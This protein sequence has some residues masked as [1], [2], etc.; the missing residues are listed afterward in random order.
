MVGFTN[1]SPLAKVCLHIHMSSH[2]QK[3]DVKEITRS[4]WQAE[5][6]P[7][8]PTRYAEIDAVI[9]NRRSRNIIKDIESD[10]VTALPSDH[11]PVNIRVK[12]ELAEN[13]NKDKDASNAWKIPKKPTEDQK[14]LS[15]KR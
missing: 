3:P 6:Q 12:L 15:A 10:T 13:R 2:F 1:S 7:Y 9:A 14:L 4:D 11:F 8:I 5:G